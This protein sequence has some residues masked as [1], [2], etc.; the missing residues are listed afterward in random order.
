MSFVCLSLYC[1]SVSLCLSLSVPLSASAKILDFESPSEILVEMCAKLVL[2]L[3]FMPGLGLGT[4]EG[5]KCL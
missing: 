3:T 1:L 2:S 5:R 4:F